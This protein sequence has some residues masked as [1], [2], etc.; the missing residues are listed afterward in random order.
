MK[1]LHIFKTGKHTAMSGVALSF[2]EDELQRAAEAYDPT[3]HEAPIVVGHP[4]DN[5]PAYGWVSRLNF[6]EGDL[7]AEPVQVDEAF[8]EMVESGRFKKISA[9]FYTPDSPSNPVPGVYYLR[10]VGFLGAQPPA[11]KG[12]RDAAFSE[13][14]DEVVEFHDYFGANAV[15]RMFRR[16]R[17]WMIAKD[18]MEEADRVLPE[19]SV[20]DLEDDATKQFESLKTE[21]APGFA[22]TDPDGVTDMTKEELKAKQDEIDA[23]RATME[24]EKAEFAEQK[25]AFADQKAAAERKAHEDYAEGL[26]ASGR[27]TPGMKGAVVAILSGLSDETTVSYAEGEKTVEAGAQT[28]LK[29]ILDAAK[30]VVDFGEH[31]GGD[32]R[33]DNDSDDAMNEHQLTEKALEY[34]EQMSRKGIDVSISDAVAHVAENTTA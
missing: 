15:A 29:A 1:T 4:Q 18:G 3:V 28:A 19:Y 20:K 26:A 5:H 13:P 21:P 14:D 6:A 23:Q 25:K 32:L 16:L 8:A 10:H 34:K 17:E 7:E 33:S 12:L 9:S 24:S 31:S 27:V 2:G 11:I 22:E 30:P